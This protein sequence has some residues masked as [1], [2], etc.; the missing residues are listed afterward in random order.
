[1]TYKIK[2]SC[3][4][5]HSSSSIQPVNTMQAL[6][7]KSRK[8]AMARNKTW[9]LSTRITLELHNEG[10]Y[11]PFVKL[12]EADAG[13]T[14]CVSFPKQTWQKLRKNICNLSTRGFRVE[15]NSHKKVVV[16]KHNKQ[17]NVCFHTIGTKGGKRHAR[18]INLN[19][20]EWSEFV[21]AVEEIDG[22]IPPR[23]D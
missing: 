19:E 6:T 10:M 21:K 14:E 17:L 20:A 18:W 1:M 2:A 4:S 16:K 3:K 23:Y 15:L 11:G 5:S 12:Q 9:T 8:E 13:E 7:A 22:V